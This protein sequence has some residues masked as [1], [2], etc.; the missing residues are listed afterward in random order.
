VSYRYLVGVLDIFD[1]R[2]IDIWWVYWR[3]LIGVLEIFDRCPGDSSS[4]SS[5]SLIGVLQIFDFFLDIFDV[6]PGHI[7]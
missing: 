7:S 4:E 2:A 6:F 3:Y 5:R 1:G